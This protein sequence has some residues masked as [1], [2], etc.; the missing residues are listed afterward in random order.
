[1]WRL[2]PFAKTFPRSC[3]VWL[4]FCVLLTIVRCSNLSLPA[5]EKGSHEQLYYL[6]SVSSF[7]Y[8]INEPLG[9]H[10]GN[11][12]SNRGPDASAELN[13]SRT[14]PYTVTS[15]GKSFWPPAPKDWLTMG[16]VLLV[17]PLAAAGGLGGGFILVPLLIIVTGRFG[18]LRP[19]IHSV[20]SISMLIMCFTCRARSA[21]SR[22]G[23]L[24]WVPADCTLRLSHFPGSSSVHQY[25]PSKWRGQH[26][27]EP[28][29]Q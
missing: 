20:C 29:T 15:D 10:A 28:A 3:L 18:Y 23:R 14:I 8:R 4:G 9:K 13:S 1:M 21:S 5:P 17:L 26:H 19:G 6:Q 2:R 25:H 7:S 22:Q 27:S 16:A 12:T 11:A 24:T